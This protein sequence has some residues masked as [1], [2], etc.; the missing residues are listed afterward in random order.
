VLDYV[1]YGVLL[2]W[3]SEAKIFNAPHGDVKLENRTIFSEDK[4]AMFTT[5]ILRGL[6]YLHLHHIAHRDLKP[7]NILLTRYIGVYSFHMH[8]AKICGLIRTPPPP[9]YFDMFS[10]ICFG[11]VDD[12]DGHCKIADFGVAH[13][14]KDEEKKESRSIRVRFLLFLSFFLLFFD[15]D[16]LR[17]L[18]LQTLLS[19]SYIGSESV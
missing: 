6:R 17:H 11:C 12:S 14:F 5:D 15:I 3:D 8:S 9:S 13:H 7:E 16:M 1:E 10:S 19:H 4:A 2:D 18:S